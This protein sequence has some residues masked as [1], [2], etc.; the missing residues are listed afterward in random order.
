MNIQMT[1]KQL[2]WMELHTEL[3]DVIGRWW[4]ENSLHSELPLIG[5]EV[6]SIMAS[7]AINILLAIKSTEDYLEGEGMRP[8][9]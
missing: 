7:S 1:T 2:E 4:A 9:K 6:I 8:G 5:D 3:K